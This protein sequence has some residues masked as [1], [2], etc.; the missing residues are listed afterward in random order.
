MDIIRKV[1]KIELNGQEMGMVLDFESAI[2]Y[3]ELTGE[4]ILKGVQRISK[5]MDI[6]A[7]CCLMASVL[8]DKNDNLVG[9]DFIKKLD[10]MNGM[11]FF[12]DNIMQL[13]ENAMPKDDDKKK[14]NQVKK[15]EK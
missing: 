11:N 13:M 15:M 6:K 5:E 2:T 14:I 4:S 9:I 8:R 3:Q 1:I 10:M 7:L 12:M